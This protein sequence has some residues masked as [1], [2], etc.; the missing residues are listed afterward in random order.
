MERSAGGQD[1]KDR[2]PGHDSKNRT[3][4]RGKLGTRVLE[5]DKWAWTAATGQLGQDS[6]DSTARTG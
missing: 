5:Q 6:W 1:R 4:G 3:A 2:T